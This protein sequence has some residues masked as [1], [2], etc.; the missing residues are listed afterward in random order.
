MKQYSFNKVD[1]IIDQ[2]TVSGFADSASIITAT[3]SVNAHNAVFDA[4]GNMNTSTSANVSG[5]ISFNLLHTSD[6]NQTLQARAILDQS[7]GLADNSEL[8]TPLHAI[9]QDK[10]GGTLVTGTTGFIPKVPNIARGNAFSVLNWNIMFERIDWPDHA[11]YTDI[12]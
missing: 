8:F 4:K 2:E 10:M 7:K 1:F 6:T 9:I 5:V 12:L 11:V 3:R